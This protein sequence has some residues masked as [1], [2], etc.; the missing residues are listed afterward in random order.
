MKVTKDQLAAIIPAV[1]NN[2]NWGLFVT[3]LNGYADL[4]HVDTPLRM[5]HFLAQVAHETAELVYLRELGNANYCYKYEVGNLGKTLGNTH[6]GDGYKY[7]G[8]GFLHLTG[9]ANYQ[10]YQ[11]S[12]YCVGNIMDKPQLLEQPLGAVKSGMWYWWKNG[13]NKVADKDDVTA[14]TKKINGG[15]NG[16]ARR[17]EYLA[18]AKKAFGIE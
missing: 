18:K 2:H 11:D 6:K 13:L 10:A 5:A 3:Y 12:E 16:L 17:K 9:R 1:K 14:V 15:T 7:K 8:R 4:F